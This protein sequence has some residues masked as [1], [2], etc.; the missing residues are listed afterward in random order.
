[1]QRHREQ[2][3]KLA[4]LPQSISLQ[5]CLSATLELLVNCFNA[6]EGKH[7][8]VLPHRSPPL[9]LRPYR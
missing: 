8:G 3:A 5:I 7:V 1:M 6:T 9:M 4:T 2:W